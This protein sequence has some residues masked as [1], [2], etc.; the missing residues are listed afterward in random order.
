M[1]SARRH[2][3]LQERS[4][5]VD[6]PENDRREKEWNP[7]K[8][9]LI[10]QLV[11][12]LDRVDAQTGPVG[13]KILHNFSRGQITLEELQT[14]LEQAPDFGDFCEHVY[15]YLEREGVLMRKGEDFLVDMYRLTH[16][17]FA[18]ID[19]KKYETNRIKKSRKNKFSDEWLEQNANLHH[20]RLVDLLQNAFLQQEVY[21]LDAYEDWEKSGA[22]PQK[23]PEKKFLFYNPQSTTEAFDRETIQGAHFHIL[24][25][26]IFGKKAD[27]YSDNLA[28]AA[29]DEVTLACLIFHP[30]Y[31]DGK[32]ESGVLFVRDHETR[33]YRKISRDWF[34]KSGMKFGGELEEGNIRKFLASPKFF[35]AEGGYPHLT[36]KNLLTATD[37][38]TMAGSE[39]AEKYGT[40]RDITQKRG[41]VMIDK[42]HYTL[43]VEFAPTSEKKY[44]LY[45]LSEMVGGIVEVDPETGEDI[46][47]THVIDMV[48]KD[49]PRRAE[50]KV[51]TAPQTSI[52]IR[53]FNTEESKILFEK[54]LTGG[55][56]FEFATLL[57]LKQKLAKKANVSFES[58]SPGE[59]AG[60][61]LVYR[62][63]TE[64]EQKKMDSF[65]ETKKEAGFPVLL[66]G[67]Y[68]KNLFPLLEKIDQKYSVHE[69]AAIFEKIA[70]VIRSLQTVEE[71]VKEFFVEEGKEINTNDI[72]Q[73]I[74]K[75]A[76]K[77]I[78]KFATEPKATIKIS[79]LVMRL[80]RIK[81]DIM[82]FAVM[83]K[84]AVK[85][86]KHIDVKEVKGMDLQHL[87]FEELTDSDKEQMDEIIQKNWSDRDLYGEK[88]IKEFHELMK[89]DKNSRYYVMRKDGKI[90]SFIRFKD[91]EKV[92]GEP[93]RK[94]GGY[95]NVD[96]DFRGSGFGEAMMLASII[97]EG[98]TGIIDAVVH[99]DFDIGIRY[100][101][102]TGC[103][104]VGFGP[105]KV[106]TMRFI[107]E[108]DDQKNKKSFTR[109][110]TEE[111]VMN[112]IVN[113]S[114]ENQIRQQKKVIGI[115]FN[116]KSRED[117]EKIK[118]LAREGYR[119]TRY[120][121][122][123]NGKGRI[124]VFE[125][126]EQ[127][128]MD[129][130]QSKIAR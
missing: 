86:D 57:Q 12:V 125:L 107:L 9:F 49:D 66:L 36:E 48:G 19:N 8:T 112:F 50:R 63:C 85:G 130:I 73:E 79:E 16:R 45:Q 110:Q 82:L 21:D 68:E 20:G 95:F 78:E 90:T 75:R 80:S 18:G 53:D 104:I 7:E 13:R 102:E 32:R 74:M 41:M 37:F 88:K 38:K 118:L 89:T 115:N 98:E 54:H 42:V 123:P 126:D 99:P 114:V 23:K 4:L 44:R 101:E 43:G 55:E 108:C 28:D 52:H 46:Q 65:L 77:L 111:E 40:S 29:F 58:L 70:D 56:A 15:D 122:N 91:K 84:V 121:N 26:E 97:K 119:G 33:E 22:N 87:N 3:I 39:Y 105:D 128:R 6:E 116:P 117:G 60:L 14:E 92:F 81:E 72:S 1:Q 35:L 11:G 127:K 51:L 59:Q 10:R 83:F 103:D 67:Q 100:V 129:I 24:P 27:H 30:N 120:F 71:K 113:D 34:A 62:N 124:I 61:L 69:Q 109:N 25:S 64:E 2:E 106:G 76:A 17:K 31:G 47:M 5:F 93:I 96:P 94:E